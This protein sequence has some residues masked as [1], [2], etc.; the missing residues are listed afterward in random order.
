MTCFTSSFQTPGLDTLDEAFLRESDAGSIA[1]WGSTGLGL[2][3]GHEVLL[4]SF[5]KTVYQSE[6]KRVGIAAVA[7][8]VTLSVEKPYNLDL[9]DTY[10]ILGDPATSINITP[11]PQGI[12]QIFLT[13][14][15]R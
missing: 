14:V 5:V 6:E 13:T 2:L 12:Y 9:L 4:D 8:K 1:S 10:T 11:K 15:H 7:A 3:E